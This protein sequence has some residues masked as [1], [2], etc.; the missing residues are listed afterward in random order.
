MRW[1]LLSRRLKQFCRQ[2]RW[3]LIGHANI[4]QNGLTNGGLHLNREGNDSLHSN[5]VN[6]LKNNWSPG[7]LNA[8]SPV[9]VEPLYISKGNS[10]LY[11]SSL[12]TAASETSYFS[13]SLPAKRG[14]QIAS[15]NVKSLNI[16]KNIL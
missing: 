4:T 14:F 8:E 2:N 9:S 1:K 13:N 7:S 16:L 12:G 15:I 5:F 3:K 10:S 6:F 11:D